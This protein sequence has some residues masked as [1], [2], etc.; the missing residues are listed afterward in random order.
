MP[1]KH[2]ASDCLRDITENA[3]RVNAYTEGL[4]LERFAADGLRRDAVERC[5]ERVCEAA[6]RLGDRAAELMP[7]QPWSQIRGLGNWL[8]HAYDR[9]DLDIV[10]KTARERLPSLAA[11]A[12]GV[13]QE[14]EAEHQV[15][16]RPASS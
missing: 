9:V 5:L 12:A 10:W 14:L 15:G 2:K 6:V 3:A 13:L 7:N 11:D 4:T 8:R 16:S 1:F